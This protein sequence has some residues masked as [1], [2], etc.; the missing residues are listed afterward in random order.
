MGRGLLW[1]EGQRDYAVVQGWR[2]WERRGLQLK[3]GGG[4]QIGVWL[5]SNLPQ[6]FLP[7]SLNSL[8]H[9]HLPLSTHSP[10]ISAPT[11]LLSFSVTATPSY[12][13]PPPPVHDISQIATCTTPRAWKGCN[14]R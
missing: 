10:P 8:I 2:G 13:S 14:Q 6:L 1:V 3:N 9:L 11:S 7:S 5:C 4:L 12:S